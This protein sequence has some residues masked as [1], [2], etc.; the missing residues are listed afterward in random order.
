MPD[1]SY[2]AAVMVI[3]FV[4][5]VALRALPF[6]ILNPLRESVFVQTMAQWMP[7]GILSILAVATFRS[8]AFAG[9][10]HLPAA[11]VAVGVAAATHLLFGRRTLL[12]VGLGTLT[13]VLLVNL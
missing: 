3:V 5:T 4:I 10:G 8:S 11:V 7:V 1:T 9:N 12:S 13:F 6:A 2:L